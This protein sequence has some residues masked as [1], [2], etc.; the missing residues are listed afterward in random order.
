MDWLYVLDVAIEREKGSY[1][2][3]SR[4]ADIT[5]DARGKEMFVW[6]AHQELEHFNS[7]GGLKEALKEAS[8][9]VERGCLSVWDSKIIESMPKSEASGEITTSVTALAALQTAIQMERVAIELYRRVERSTLDSSIKVTFRELVT[10]EKNHLLLLKA[11]HKA[12][13]ES[14]AFIA[15]DEFASP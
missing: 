6:L 2:F 5:H 8:S 13:E 3:Y 1:D 9:G 11:Q 7:L 10:E 12:I 14:Q 15:M 4:A